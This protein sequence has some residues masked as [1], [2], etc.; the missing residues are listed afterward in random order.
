MNKFLCAVAVFVFSALRARATP[1]AYVEGKRVA[2]VIGNSAYVHAVTLPNPVADG[3]L[4][5]ETLRSAGF[6]V[7]EGSDLDKAGDEQAS[8]PV[9]R[10][11]LRRRHRAW[12]TMP[13]MA[14]RWTDATT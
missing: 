6:S 10:G 11:R 3:K 2:L 4:I 8:R 1:A 13:A 14:C 12:S 5:A 9:H 7:I